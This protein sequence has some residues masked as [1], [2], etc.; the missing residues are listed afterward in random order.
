VLLSLTSLHNSY[1]DGINDI[2]ALHTDL[3]IIDLL[4]SL[5]FLI[6][7]LLLLVSLRG[8][9]RHLDVRIYEVLSHSDLFTIL[10]CGSLHVLLI[11]NLLLGVAQPHKGGLNLSIGDARQLLD[12]EV[13]EIRVLVEKEQNYRLVAVHHEDVRFRGNKH[14]LDLYA[15]MVQKPG[16]VAIGELLLV[17]VLELDRDVLD[18]G[19]QCAGCLLLIWPVTVSKHFRTKVHSHSCNLVSLLCLFEFINKIFGQVNIIK[20]GGKLVHSIVTT[21]NLQLLE[22]Q[23]LSFLRDEGF[24]EETVSEVL[25]V[26]LN[27]DVTTVKAAEEAD[28]GI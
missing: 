11:E 20:H 16:Q 7:L 27:E 4:S 5:V 12:L 17:E 14:R 23:K 24:V 15:T 8:R 21:L 18:F 13:G 19:G 28:D 1:D 22:H 26:R 6:I 25:C 2:L 3:L 10:E 9:V